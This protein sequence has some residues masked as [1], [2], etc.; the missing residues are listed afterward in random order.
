M[1]IQ[2]R[3]LS[4]IILKG[5]GWEVSGDSGSGAQQRDSWKIHGRHR[6]G[7]HG[8]QHFAVSVPVLLRFI[9]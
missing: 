4:E 9:H 1:I 5:R 2:K 3:I 7:W 8:K 6:V